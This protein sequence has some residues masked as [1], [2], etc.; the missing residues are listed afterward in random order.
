MILTGYNN[1]SQ[2]NNDKHSQEYTTM[3]S[4]IEKFLDTEAYGGNKIV[5]N[6]I[7]F[8]NYLPLPAHIEHGWTAISKALVSDIAIAKSKKLMLVFSQ[9]RLEAWNKANS[10][11]AV[12]SGSPFIIYRRK[13]NIN[14]P[15]TRSG[16]I[17]FPSHST[18]I[19]PSHY[20]INQY[21]DSLQK[22]PKEFQPV[23]ICLLKP[24][25]DMGRD[26]EYLAR[27]FKVVTAGK[28]L[29]GSL[30]FVKNFYE[31]LKNHKYATSNDIGTYT[32]YSVEMGIPFFLHGDR[33]YSSN[34]D[35]LDVNIG[36][37][38][39]MESYKYGRI[40]NRLFDTGPTTSISPKQ[41]LFVNS[42]MGLSD[43]LSKVELKKTIIN[44]TKRWDYWLVYVPLYWL[45]SLIKFLVPKKLAYTLFMYLSGIRKTN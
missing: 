23:T 29:R 10:I 13:H 25:I 4:L 20:N 19:S 5:K 18:L 8:P 1:E 17:A 3:S 36:K 12:I 43:S 24:D 27:G 40:A 33:S 30:D 35:G 42:E 39:Y 41:R 34:K 15:T 45:L 21:C 31:L 28:N 6:Y 9:R 7:S 44:N 22:L 38:A 2:S 14:C 32:F 26:K 37:I 11:K 16:T